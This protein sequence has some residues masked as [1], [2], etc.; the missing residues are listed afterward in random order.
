MTSLG[1]HQCVT[2]PCVYIREADIGLARDL[3]WFKGM[4]GKKFETT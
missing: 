3:L 1:F 4:V 2:N